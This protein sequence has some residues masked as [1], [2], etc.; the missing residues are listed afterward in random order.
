MTVSERELEDY[1]CEHPETLARNLRMVGRQI[2]LPHGVMDLLGVWGRAYAIELKTRPLHERDIGQVLRYVGD[3]MAI[4]SYYYMEDRAPD[5]P[6][7]DSDTYTR[8]RYNL[9]LSW[10]HGLGGA[11]NYS[12]GGILVGT[13]ASETLITA[14]DGAGVCV[15]IW[16]ECN[17]EIALECVG[18][19][20]DSFSRNPIAG[21]YPAW[22]DATSRLLAQETMAELREGGDF[23]VQRLCTDIRQAASILTGP[24]TP[25][26]ARPTIWQN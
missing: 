5:C 15:F 19:G 20:G 8:E 12:I 23:F 16:K 13:G 26:G 6:A 11:W 14:A 21:H 22:V 9:A 1:I 2:A 25:A 3:L 10:K 18:S 7:P 4:L 17:K 24:F